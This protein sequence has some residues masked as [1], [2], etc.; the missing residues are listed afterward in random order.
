[1]Y[2]PK[3]YGESKSVSCPFCSKPAL[4]KNK[5]KIPVCQS[6]VNETLPDIKCTCGSYL[7]LREGKF[8][9]F[10]TCIN[11]GAVNFNKGMEMLSLNKFKEQKEKKP[12]EAAIEQSQKSSIISDYGKYK[13]FDYGIE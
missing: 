1:M 4:S 11:C 3:R 12:V 8:G 5:Q 10:F 13:D 7:D 9:P 2:I 6:H